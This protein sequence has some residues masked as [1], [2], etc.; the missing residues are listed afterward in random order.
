MSPMMGYKWTTTCHLPIMQTTKKEKR[1]K[2][3]AENTSF[4]ALTSD[5]C[6]NRMTSLGE[7]PDF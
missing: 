7:S 1:K 4:N 2:K 5:T 3:E 6:R